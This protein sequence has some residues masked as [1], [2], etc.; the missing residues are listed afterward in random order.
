MSSVI[1]R[2]DLGNAISSNCA[3]QVPPIVSDIAESMI[4]LLESAPIP[5]SYSYKAVAVNLGFVC[6]V[7]GD[8]HPFDAHLRSTIVCMNKVAW[9]FFPQHVIL[10]ANDAIKVY[11]EKDG[12]KRN[13]SNSLVFTLFY[14]TPIHF[15][16]EA[17]KEIYYQ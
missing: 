7:N 2:A 14:W 8:Y 9:I 10:E 15:S 3:P 13:K 12:V 6:N 4:W 16:F 17:L 11:F 1:K 5:L